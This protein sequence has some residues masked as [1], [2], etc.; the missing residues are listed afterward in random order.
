MSMSP[1]DKIE[2]V[3]IPSKKQPEKIE[4]RKHFTDE[5][6]TPTDWFL[7]EHFSK[8]LFGETYQVQRPTVQDKK[9]VD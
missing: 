4:K 6:A 7:L 2:V 3:Q 9:E 5:D 1:N 8:L